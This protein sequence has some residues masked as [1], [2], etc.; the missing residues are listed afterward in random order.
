MVVRDLHKEFGCRILCV[1]RHVFSG[2]E[3]Q[4]KPIRPDIEAHLR[5]GRLLAEQ[6]RATNVF[7]RYPPR[8]DRVG[9]GRLAVLGRGQSHVERRRVML[10]QRGNDGL[11]P[12]LLG[13]GV[14]QARLKAFRIDDP[15]L[16]PSPHADGDHPATRHT[17]A[18]N[19]SCRLQE[20]GG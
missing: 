14:Q 9:R 20:G 16:V 18:T 7:C 3:N 12:L 5:P 15:Q 17:H 6:L 8:R 13:D 2:G 11:G 4:Q 19:A 10:I 1:R